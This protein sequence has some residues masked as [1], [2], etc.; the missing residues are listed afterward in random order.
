MNGTEYAPD[1]FAE[2]G[3][4]HTRSETFIAP[5]ALPR[6]GAPDSPRRGAAD[7]GPPRRHRR[8]ALGDGQRARRA[9]P[10][11]RA[12]RGSTLHDGLLPLRGRA[13]RSRTCSASRPRC[14]SSTTTS[15][16]ASGRPGARRRRVDRAARALLD[17]AVVPGVLGR[18]PLR[19]L[20]VPVLLER[21]GL[22]LRHLVGPARARRGRRHAPARR[23][24]AS[25]SR[26]CGRNGPPRTWRSGCRWSSSTSTPRPAAPTGCIP[27]YFHSAWLDTFF[28]HVVVDALVDVGPLRVEGVPVEGGGDQLGA[29]RAWRA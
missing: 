14:R 24:C 17:R 29:R 6:A 16:R 9:G 5:P 8:L 23:R 3:W 18:E 27:D 12:R 2:A 11:R 4:D 22:E 19:R 10:A 20:R 15:G 1:F 13:R 21:P 7:A 25:A 26:A 28:R